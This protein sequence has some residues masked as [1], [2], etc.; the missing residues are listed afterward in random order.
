MRRDARHQFRHLP[1]RSSE[2][3]DVSIARVPRQIRADAVEDAELHG[4]LQRG[5]AAP[6]ANHFVYRIRLAERQ[7]ERTADQTDAENDN[8]LQP[9]IPDRIKVADYTRARS[10]ACTAVGEFPV[11]VY[12]FKLIYLREHG[13]YRFRQF[14][15]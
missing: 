13:E 8:L 7:R 9:A 12:S 3:H 11:G 1:H 15:K 6:E 14:A 4:L 2:Q 5:L 10:V